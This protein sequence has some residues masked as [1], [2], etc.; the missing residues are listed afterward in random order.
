MCEEM[1]K[2]HRYNL[3]HFKDYGYKKTLDKW[4]LRTYI[5]A[6]MCEE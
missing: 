5:I 1:D 6:V 4:T 2:C 3:L